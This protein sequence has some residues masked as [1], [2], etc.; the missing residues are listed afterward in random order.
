MEWPRQRGF[1]SRANRAVGALTA[2]TLI[3]SIGWYRA[4]NEAR[5]E[6]RTA[7]Y[8][9]ESANELEVMVADL[10][11]RTAQ[12][13]EEMYRSEVEQGELQEELDKFTVAA[14]VTGQ[15][16]AETP[17]PSV[18][19]KKLAQDLV[20]SWMLSADPSTFWKFAT[21]VASPLV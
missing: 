14:A 11:T 5:S 8:E 16:S 1:S 12:Q 19:L 21:V 4:S 18:E 17:N 7:Q 10:L 2:V 20:N 3:A 13:R 9:S 15:G 6:R